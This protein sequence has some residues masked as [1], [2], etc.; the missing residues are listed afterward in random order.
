LHFENLNGV[1]ELIQELK[2]AM[3]PHGLTLSVA[4]LAKGSEFGP[5]AIDAIDW[6]HIMAYDMGRPH[7]TFE[8]AVA[9]LHHWES[10]GV[11][12]SKM[13]LGLPFYG[14]DADPDSWVYYPYREIVALYAPPPEA[15]DVAG[16]NFNGIKTIQTKTAYIVEQHYGGVMIWELTNDSDDTT[17][18]LTAI[19]QAVHRNTPPDFNCDNNIDM[20]DLRNLAIQWH[21]NN[22]ISENSWCDRSDLDLSGNVAAL[23]RSW[24][25]HN[26]R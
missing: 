9:A 11:P 22:C 21:R 13:V 1:V 12:R 23:W 25:G 26:T 20:L 14:R 6:L 18:L 15:D 4:V 16:I 2:A 24:C 17:S 7:S 19:A 10:F 3:Q 8:D 5:A